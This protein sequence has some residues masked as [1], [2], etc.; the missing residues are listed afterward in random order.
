MHHG[1]W[2]ST[3]PI[4]KAHADTADK[5]KPANRMPQEPS[6]KVCKRKNNQGP[7]QRLMPLPNANKAMVAAPSK[8]WLVKAA[9]INAE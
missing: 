3:K 7:S 6:P 8:G 1:A 9:T 4:H 5:A 2:F